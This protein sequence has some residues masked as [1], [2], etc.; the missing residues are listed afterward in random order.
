MKIVKYNPKFAASQLRR[1]NRSFIQKMATAIRYRGRRALRFVR[2]NKKMLIGAGALGAAGYASYKVFKA[3]SDTREQDAKNYVASFGSGLGSRANAAFSDSEIPLHT[4]SSSS[5]DSLVNATMDALRSMARSAS[6]L[7]DENTS[8]Q[9]AL[10]FAYLSSLL[11]SLHPNAGA[12]NAYLEAGPFI[13]SFTRLGFELDC[14]WSIA[15]NR[16]KKFIDEQETDSNLFERDVLNTLACSFADV[17]LRAV[18]PNSDFNY[19]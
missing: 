9:R 14:S 19:E 10:E 7:Q 2:N 3:I 8:A 11:L 16:F 6:P 12:Q 5:F 4:I 18:S 17:N 15:F 13:Q 1:A